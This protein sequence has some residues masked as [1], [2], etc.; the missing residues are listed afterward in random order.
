MS[1]ADVH[2]A[3]GIPVETIVDNYFQRSKNIDVQSIAKVCDFLN[4][5]T[6]EF[7]GVKIQPARNQYRQKVM[8]RELVLKIITADDIAR[9]EEADDKQHNTSREID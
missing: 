2:E 9:K 6:E 4:I 3:T 8:F 7:I 1:I 5:T